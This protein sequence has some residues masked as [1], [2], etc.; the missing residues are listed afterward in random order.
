MC[1]AVP[2]QLIQVDGEHGVVELGGIRRKVN[3]AFVEDAR[4]GDYVVVHTGF[5]IT[6]MDEA[7][8]AETLRLLNEC[9]EKAE[10]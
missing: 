4:P 10:M 8:A 3:L 6:R 1:L 2:L 7:E 5:A 9:I